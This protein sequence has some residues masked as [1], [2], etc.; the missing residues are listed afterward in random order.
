M[1]CVKYQFVVPIGSRKIGIKV[2]GF[3]LNLHTEKEIFPIFRPFLLTATKNKRHEKI[4][5]NLGFPNFF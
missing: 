4:A 5:N 3:A 1:H 2:S